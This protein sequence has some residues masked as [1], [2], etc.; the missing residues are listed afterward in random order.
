MNIR[1]GLTDNLREITVSLGE[2]TKVSTVKARVKAALDGKRPSL[3][4]T[5]DHG[6]EVVVSS[7]R[8]VY[9]ELIPTDTKPIGFG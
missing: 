1:I 5:D 8:I 9:V 3:W 7:A 4:L 2:D 6:R